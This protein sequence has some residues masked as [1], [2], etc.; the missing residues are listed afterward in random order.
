MTGQDLGAGHLISLEH[1]VKLA[2]LATALSAMLTALCA[3][4]VIGL[5]AFIFLKSGTWDWYRLS[6]FVDQLNSGRHDIYTTASFRATPAQPTIEQEAIAWL[7]EM[8]VVAVLLFALVLLF[9]FRRY[10]VILE[11]RT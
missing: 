7:R 6:E 4:F 5:Q 8:P 1:A 10:L 9:A 2:K 3:A 11:K